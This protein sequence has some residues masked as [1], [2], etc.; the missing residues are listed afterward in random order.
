MWGMLGKHVRP[1]L[2]F[3]TSVMAQNEHDQPLRQAR[4]RRGWSQSQAISRFETAG[5]RLLIGVPARSSLRALFSMYENGR[6]QVPQAYTPVFRELYRATDEELG[7]AP[8]LQGGGAGPGPLELP[9]SRSG[10][11]TE[12][13]PALLEFLAEVCDVHGR[14]D[15]EF[16][17]RNLI[18]SVSAHMPLIEE[19]GQTARGE[20]REAVLRIAARFAG[21]AGWLCQ[22][23]GH[24]E[25]AVRWTSRALEY[26][27]ELGEPRLRAYLLM[28]RS[29]IATEAD[30]PGQGLG[31]ANAALRAPKPLTPRIR[32]VA[33]RQRANAHALLGEKADFERAAADALEQAA[34]GD[35][36]E[37][38][39][40]YCTPAYVEMESAT[41]LAVLGRPGEAIE[42]FE[43]SLRD[44]PADAQ[45]RDR[46]LC[47]ARLAAASAAYGDVERAV[48]AAAQALPV[49]VGTGSARICKQLLLASQRLESAC[50]PDVRDLLHEI[51]G[52]GAE[53]AR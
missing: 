46:G 26:A 12:P 3:C 9:A 49:A 30:F 42:V 32:A 41:S 23:A 28:R 20:Q 21:F 19:L 52:L 22:D 27:D 16:G 18:A 17:P 50:D 47:L 48:R 43:A 1:A 53:D 13:S 25:L 10:A 4:L 51:A 39:A 11:P 33:L 35:D 7:F 2:A 29:N 36:G 14:A 34:D 6:R 8:G 45:G 37:W 15:A 40:G 24:T 38:L 31:L 44:W 5:R